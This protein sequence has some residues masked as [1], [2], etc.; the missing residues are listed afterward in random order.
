[1]VDRLRGEARLGVLDPVAGGDVSRHARVAAPVRG[2]DAR[3]RVGRDGGV[4]VGVEGVVG[5]AEAQ[6][7]EVDAAGAVLDV[8][9]AVAAVVPA[10]AARRAAVGDG[11]V[12]VVVAA[13]GRGAAGVE[14][15]D[16]GV[17]RGGLAVQVGGDRGGG[18]DGVLGGAALVDDRGEAAAVGGV[19]G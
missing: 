17:G 7:V 18:G 19:E 8:R 15:G 1:H 6:E 13:E 5:A 3:A 2:A 16:V 10:H 9:D 11:V 12:Q 4:G 14:A